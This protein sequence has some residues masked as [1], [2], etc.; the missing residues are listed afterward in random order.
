MHEIISSQAIYVRAISQYI[1]RCLASQRRPD[2]DGAP[3]PKRPSS[4]PQQRT[5]QP[6]TSPPPVISPSPMKENSITRVSSE[7]NDGAS[8]LIQAYEKMGSTN[9]IGIPRT[10]SS[11]ADGLTGL[12][13]MVDNMESLAVS[14]PKKATTLQAPKAQTPTSTNK[15]SK[16][17][18]QNGDDDGDLKALLAAQEDGKDQSA[19]E[20]EL[21]DDFSKALAQVEASHGLSAEETGALPIVDVQGSIFASTDFVTALIGLNRLVFNRKLSAEDRR[22]VLFGSDQILP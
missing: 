3:T 11:S 14:T 10:L 2:E 20:T 18:T 21:A 13:S 5:G 19:R 22:R 7:Q 17:S 9:P 12:A 1:R 6:P 8:N 4:A 16:Q 15:L